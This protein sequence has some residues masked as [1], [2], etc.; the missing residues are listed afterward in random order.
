MADILAGVR[1]IAQSDLVE[2][3]EFEKDISLISFGHEAVTDLD[4]HMRKLETAMA[5]EHAGMLVL[6][7]DGEICG[8][9]WMTAKRN[10][11]TNEKYV[12]F[13]SFYIKE[14]YRG[15]EYTKVLFDAGMAF[16]RN[17]GAKRIVGKVHA[18]N[19]PMRVLYKSY[20]FE[21]T[22]ITMEYTF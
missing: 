2:I 10:S 13:R 16:S 8:W 12:N 1:E 6:D 5:K 3:A 11:V 19:L 14:A 21:P 9:L 4:F 7:H 17:T 20:Q 18:S 22:H 15:T